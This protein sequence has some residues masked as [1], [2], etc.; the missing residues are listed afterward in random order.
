MI[1][2]YVRRGQIRR[3]ISDKGEQVC[4]IIDEDG[5]GN[6]RK[7]VYVT[8]VEFVHRRD[9]EWLEITEDEM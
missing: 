6:G 2:I 5:N 7:E 4:Y 1:A 9:G 3:V 8:M